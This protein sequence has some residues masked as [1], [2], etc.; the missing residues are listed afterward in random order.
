MLGVDGG[1]GLLATLRFHHGLDLARHVLRRANRHVSFFHELEQ[2]CLDPP[3]AD[4]ARIC[5]VARHGNFVDLVQVNDA[6]LCPL[7][8]IVR[9]T[10]EFSHEVLHIGT[11]IASLGEFSRISLHEG[12]A[13]QIGYTADEVGFSHPCRAYENNVLL[14]IVGG[15]LALQSQSDMVVVVA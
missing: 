4:V 2:V 5:L 8:V 6:E 3:S 12:H 9:S 15:F 1:G 11:D 7:N 10:I 13:D 14:G